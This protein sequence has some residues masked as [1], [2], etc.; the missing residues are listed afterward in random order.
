MRRRDVLAVTGGTLAALA[1]CVGAT[2]DSTPT[3]TAETPP[4]ATCDADSLVADAPESA[5][6]RPSS[7]THDRIGDYVTQVESDF[8]LSSDV[9]DGYVKI[10]TPTV[11][12]V[13]HGYLARVPVNGGYYNREKEGNTTETVH[14]DL[15]MHKSSYF[16]N[17]QVVRRAKR[18]DSFPDPRKRSDL[19]ACTSE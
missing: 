14:Y 2:G 8:V 9:E 4:Y 19:I 16:L 1:G 17:E 12:S 13:T 3:G 11:E 7:L 18:R 5:R 6:N 10:G 15:G